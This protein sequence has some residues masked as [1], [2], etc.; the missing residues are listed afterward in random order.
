MS[1]SRK[2][3]VALLAT[4]NHTLRYEDV[5][6]NS[7]TGVDRLSIAV[8]H[9]PVS[10]L[11]PASGRRK[12]SQNRTQRGQYGDSIDRK[13]K[14]GDFDITIEKYIFCLNLFE[15]VNWRMLID[16]SHDDESNALH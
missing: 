12:T 10:Q 3:E 14:R 11:D 1:S 15:R 5:T 6:C 16:L 2:G 9:F 4:L 8:S 7:S 13:N